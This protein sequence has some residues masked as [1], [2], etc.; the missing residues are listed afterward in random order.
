MVQSNRLFYYYEI[1]I[2]LDLFHGD[3]K[4]KVSY[5]KYRLTSL[6]KVNEVLKNYKL[7]KIEM[8]NLSGVVIRTNHLVREQF[9]HRTGHNARFEIMRKHK[10]STRN[11]L[12]TQ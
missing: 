3:S 5:T 11:I 4:K 9:N 8:K 10:K 7:K 6:N 1:N 12:I 2:V